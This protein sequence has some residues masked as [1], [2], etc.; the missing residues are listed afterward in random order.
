MG[1]TS[2]RMLHVADKCQHQTCDGC[3]QPGARGAFFDLCAVF[4]SETRGCSARVTSFTEPRFIG[5]WLGEEK[6]TVR[7][8]SYQV[9]T[10]SIVSVV[11]EF[12]RGKEG[13]KRTASTHRCRNARPS[14]VRTSYLRKEQSQA[15]LGL[16]PDTA[17]RVKDTDH[18][19]RS[20]KRHQAKLPVDASC[21]AVRGD[22]GPVQGPGQ[23][24]ALKTRAQ[25]PG[26]LLRNDGNT[27][28]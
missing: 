9:A 3:G 17:R 23:G 24:Q 27:Q 14:T 26:A 7:Y 8:S 28:C 20:T 18:G 21:P 11:Y 10:I 1:V 15:L 16:T 25:W 12:T 19:S 2:V 13:K 5:T 6:V 4:A 22:P